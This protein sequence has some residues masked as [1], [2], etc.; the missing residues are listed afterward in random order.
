MEQQTIITLLC[1]WSYLPERL[2]DVVAEVRT[3]EG[4]KGLASKT[5]L[6]SEYLWDDT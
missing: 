1:F 4:S 6:L 3:T 5:S 2:F